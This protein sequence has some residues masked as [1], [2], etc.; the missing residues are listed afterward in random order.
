VEET[1]GAFEYA[2]EV[3]L[4][5]GKQSSRRWKWRGKKVVEE[6]L[7]HLIDPIFDEPGRQQHGLEFTCSQKMVR[8]GEGAQGVEGLRVGDDDGG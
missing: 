4:A 5:H 6:V 7:R 3:E 2:Q 1:A 8:E